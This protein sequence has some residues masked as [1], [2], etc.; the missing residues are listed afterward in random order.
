VHGVK[1]WFR[2]L[3]IG[4]TLSYRALFDWLSP[5]IMI[6]SFLVTPVAQ[7]LLFAYIGRGAGVASDAFFVIGNA[8]QYSAIPCLFG[9]TNTV[10]AERLQGTL[11]IVFAS[12]A[13]RLALILGRSL[14]VM[15]NGF[16]VSVFGLFA[17][18][19]IM[20]VPV[21]P[22]DFGWIAV[23]VLVCNVACSG[24]GLANAAVGLRFRDVAVLANVSF[25]ILLIFSGA[26]I[27]R[28]T[29]PRWMAATGDWLPLTHG[30][31]A[32]RKLATGSGITA[33]THLMTTELALGAGYGLL[34]GLL[35]WGLERQSRRAGSMD[36]V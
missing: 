29:L 5:W 17:G 27:P 7:I 23:A 25:G 10:V 22:A 24:L 3:V 6:P 19:T 31:E 9:M 13:P 30:I 21:H 20:R 26:N 2:I 28:D 8:V 11:G 14:P 18:C 1:N 16:V 4:G 15:V 33:V 12:P 34:G 32:T 35:L 36:L